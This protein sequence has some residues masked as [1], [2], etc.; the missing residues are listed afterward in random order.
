MQLT[1]IMQ[2]YCKN[3]NAKILAT[4]TTEPQRKHTKIEMCPAAMQNAC[5]HPPQG[6][7]GTAV[8][9]ST[10]LFKNASQAT[11]TLLEA[12][13][14]STCSQSPMLPSSVLWRALVRQNWHQWLC[15]W[16]SQVLLQ[17][18]SCRCHSH[19]GKGSSWHKQRAPCSCP[20]SDCRPPSWASPFQTQC[21]AGEERK[22]VPHFF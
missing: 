21:A 16:C 14:C 15:S 20:S 8:R 11:N 4:T 7:E 13:S 3:W 1:V 5:V 6:A 12:Q 10:F 19:R 22:M 9:S 18:Q 2:H 17:G